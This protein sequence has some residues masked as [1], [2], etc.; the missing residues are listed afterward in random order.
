[1]W[2]RVLKCFEKNILKN[3]SIIAVDP[4]M[5]FYKN[6]IGILKESS[7]LKLLNNKGENIDIP[8]NSV[9]II[10]STNVLDHC[11]NPEDVIK[12]CF[13]ILKPGGLFLPSL[14]LIY[15][16]LKPVSK[17]IKYFD[18]NH[19]HHFVMSSMKRNLTNHYSSVMLCQNIQLG[20]IKNYLVLETY[21]EV[22]KG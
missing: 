22:K 20:R 16:Y 14:H 8:D 10:F 11:E 18:K 3:I 21:L 2:Q 17:L 9:D 5:D 7:N 6:E 15:D 1:M 13:R 4:L 19:P 12:E